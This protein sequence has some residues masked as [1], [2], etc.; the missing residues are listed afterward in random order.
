MK[1]RNLKSN[2]EILNYFLEH[3]E[4]YGDKYVDGVREALENEFI[5]SIGE[6]CV[7][8]EF[9]QIFDLMGAI[10]PCG[11]HYVAYLDLLKKCFDINCNILEVGG[12]SIPTFG[13]Y[14]AL[15]QLK[16]GVG[17]ITVYDP[18]LVS[19][20][21]YGCRNLHLHKKEITSNSDIKAYDL[22]VGIMPCLGTD[23]M[24]ELIEKFK[25]DFFIAFCGCDHDAYRLGYYPYG[26]YRP[27][28]NYYL[29]YAKK[30]CEEN[31]LGELVVDYL[32]ERFE[33]PFPIVYNKRKQG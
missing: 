24:L 31:D 20:K 22:I 12:G 16:T 6:Q 11:N 7:I 10:A 2:Q 33:I 4:Q 8:S 15:E 25:K 1:W 32:P 18:M 30:I 9:T 21:K 27:S 14:I 13:K 19:R 26:F 23:S 17:T 28:Y 5:F 3:M 29:K